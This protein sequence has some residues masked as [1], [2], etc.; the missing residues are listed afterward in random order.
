M[1]AL[2]SGGIQSVGRSNDGSGVA[3]MINGLG[4]SARLVGS[5]GVGLGGIEVGIAV[6]ASSSNGWKGVG[7]GVASGGTVT[8]RSAVEVVVDAWF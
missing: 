7:V 6:M 5:S 4:V 3:V 8:R 2:M 1:G